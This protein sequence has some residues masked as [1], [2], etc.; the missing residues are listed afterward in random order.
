MVDLQSHKLQ[1]HPTLNISPNYDVTNG[2]NGTNLIT[3]H[4]DLTNA[5]EYELNNLPSGSST[6]F[7]NWVLASNANSGI[8]T[9]NA[10]L[11]TSYKFTTTFQ[12]NLNQYFNI[13]YPTN[14]YNMMG[15]VTI[16]RANFDSNNSFTKLG[17]I[18]H[19]SS[20]ANKWF[21]DGA[22]QSKGNNAPTFSWNSQTTTSGVGIT[23]SEGTNNN[24]NF[25]ALKDNA[26]PP[27]L[28]GLGINNRVGGV[29]ILITLD[30]TVGI[31]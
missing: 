30:I 24:I 6:D 14:T 29:D 1:L 4:N 17:M 15:L 3:K 26:S 13:W 11:K 16:N 12:L 2:N 18:G 25:F 21:I 10:Q 8:I 5:V 20:D 31:K 27:N 9:H 22:W 28:L 7:S 23:N 19:E